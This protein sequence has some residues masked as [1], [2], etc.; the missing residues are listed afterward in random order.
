MALNSVDFVVVVFV[1][2]AMS[3]L[4]DHWILLQKKIKSKPKKERK[5]KKRKNKKTRSTDPIICMET[6]YISWITHW[7]SYTNDYQEKNEQKRT[8]FGCFFCKAI[9]QH[10]GL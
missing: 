8:W 3:S 4:T 1:P 2:A 6:K 10:S 9:S 5:R 7:S